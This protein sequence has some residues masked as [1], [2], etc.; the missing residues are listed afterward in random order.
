MHS[1]RVAIVLF[2]WLVALSMSRTEYF[3][4]MFHS[5]V[6]AVLV[7]E[8]W[9]TR[10]QVRGMSA[11]DQR[12]TLITELHHKMS[13]PLKRLQANTNAQLINLAKK[14]GPKRNQNHRQHHIA[15]LRKVLR[16]FRWVPIRKANTMSDDDVVRLVIHKIHKSG[17][18]SRRYLKRM[19]LPELFKA[20]YKTKTN[21]N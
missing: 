2:V 14:S 15:K 21:P 6:G 17:G 12:N 19:N 4:G 1:F 13:I 18:F 7:K 11:D 16:D 10:Q 20:A 8:G 3:F 5:P 9:R